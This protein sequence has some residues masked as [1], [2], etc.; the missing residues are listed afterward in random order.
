M[1]GVVT[2]ERAPVP[3]AT[4]TVLLLNLEGW[5]SGPSVRTDA[6]G[7]YRV[8]FM[9]VP[10]SNRGPAGTEEAVAFAQVEASGYERFARYVLGTTQDLVENFH[11]HRIRRITP[12]ESAVLI[13]APDDGVCAIDVVP[14]RELLCGSVRVVASRA[15]IMRVAAVPTRA[16]S[17]FPRLAVYGGGTGGRGN[18]TSIRVA[19]G[20]EY[21]VDVQ[22]AW[23]ISGSQSFV[24]QTSMAV[25]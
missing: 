21:T 16:G 13:I 6:S 18:P 20:T 10:G 12:G 14:S 8:A 23:G 22:V 17:E 11:V 1:T 19:A 25:Q 3:G 2:D 5:Y 9:G 24:V 15:G 7:N 4:V